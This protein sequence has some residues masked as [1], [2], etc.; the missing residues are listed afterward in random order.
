MKLKIFSRVICCILF[1]IA[2]IAFTACEDNSLEA[3]LRRAQEN[4]KNAEE[5]YQKSKDNASRLEELREQYDALQTKINGLQKGS[6]AY[7][8]AIEEN[9]RLVKQIIK[10]FPEMEPYVTAK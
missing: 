8:E 2:I 6:T 4:T 7:Q 3:Q 10:E 5:V 9:N 1:V